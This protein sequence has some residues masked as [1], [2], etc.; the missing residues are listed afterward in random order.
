MKKVSCVM[1]VLVLLLL[2]VNV[3]YGTSSLAGPTGRRIVTQA[4]STA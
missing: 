4:A 2:S 1:L 3:S